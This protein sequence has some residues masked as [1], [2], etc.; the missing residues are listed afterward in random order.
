VNFFR[1]THKI[2]TKYSLPLLVVTTIVIILFFGLRPKNWA[3]TNNIHW[4][5]EQK[6][7][8]FQ[9]PSIAYVNDLSTL[10]NQQNL[11]E[12][13]IQIPV[14][15][16]DTR[17][18]GFRPVFMLHNG[19][20]RYQL[21]AWQWGASIIVMNGNDYDYS[22][23]TPRISGKD[24]LITGEE[25]L[26]TITSSKLGSRL[27]INGALATEATH[28]QLTI[29]NGHK[30]LRLIL[31]N[32]VYGKHNWEGQIYGLALNRKALSIEKVTYYYEK[33]VNQRNL[34]FNASDQ[35]L[36]SYSFNENKGGVILDDTGHN[37]Q[38]QLPAQHVVLKKTFLA[39]PWHRFRPNLT[40]LIDV[41]LNLIGFIPLGSVIYYWSS[42][43]KTLPK[44]HEIRLI[45]AFCFLLSLSIEILQAWLPHRYSSVLDL[46]LNTLGAWL[47][48]LL[49]AMLLKSKRNRPAE[50]T[51]K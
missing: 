34:D 13:T 38:L 21:S 33:W 37:L 17:Q 49:V 8:E 7:L 40:F 44:K 18:H 41:T 30:K 48:V 35:P 42:Q 45:L 12:F 39:L 14:V 31:G 15:P 5:A 20:D 50:A 1:L 46:S 19:E 2:S 43:S 23:R 9:S 6:A 4:L 36:L 28:T 27:F 26:I 47:G 25:S 3:H 51:I 32:S 10:F 22:R 11:S 24:A 29:P 16:A